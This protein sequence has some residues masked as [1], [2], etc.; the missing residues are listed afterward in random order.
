MLNKHKVSG[1]RVI[2]DLV[3]Q[4]GLPYNSKLGLIKFS[5]VPSRIYT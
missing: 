5:N 3:N 1:S 2:Y 4:F